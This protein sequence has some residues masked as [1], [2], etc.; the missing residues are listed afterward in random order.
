MSNV[1]VAFRDTYGDISCVLISENGKIDIVKHAFEFLEDERSHNKQYDVT[2][3]G[4]E[5]FLFTQ[6]L[7]RKLGKSAIGDLYLGKDTVE[8]YPDNGCHILNI[9]SLTLYRVVKWM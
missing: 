3:A 6:W 9:V 7:C 2:P 4:E 1:S 5:M 8:E